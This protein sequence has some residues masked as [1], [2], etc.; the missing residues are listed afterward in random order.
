MARACP[1]DV[2]AGDVDGMLVISKVHVREI[3]RRALEK[4]EGEEDV[5]RAI[6]QGERTEAVFAR[7]GIM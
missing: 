7:T 3:V 6:L 2:I 5:R 4:V 1:G